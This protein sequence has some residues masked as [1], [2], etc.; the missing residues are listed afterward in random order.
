MLGWPTQA[1]LFRTAFIKTD[2]EPSRGAMRLKVAM[3]SILSKEWNLGKSG[4]QKTIS[5]QNI[6]VVHTKVP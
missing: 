3:I 2:R 5:S 4:V 1:A 6:R